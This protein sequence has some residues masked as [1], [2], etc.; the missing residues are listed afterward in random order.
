MDTHP[1]D[2]SAHVAALDGGSASDAAHDEHAA[3]NLAS[4]DERAPA[5]AASPDYHV[6]D[7]VADPG[8]ISDVVRFDLPRLGDVG[9]LCG[10]HLQCHVGTDT[11]SLA[12]LGA[13]MTGLDFSPVAIDQARALAER[14]GTPA[15]FVVSDVYAAV[16]VLEPGA[17]DLVFTGIGA[18]CWI[19]DIRRW[20]GVVSDLLAP[21]GRLFLREGHP[22]LW[23]LA[24]PDDSGTLRVEHPYFERPEPTRW[25]EG[26]T[27]VQTDV[28]FQ[29]NVSYE[30]NHGLGE[31]VTALLDQ[32][33]QITGLVEHDSIP[34][35]GL[36]G[37]MEP[38][39]GGELRLI[40]RP[41]RLAASYT[42]QATKPG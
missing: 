19:P 38:I 11:I 25:D 39:G 13:R 7:F 3:V 23:A 24:D 6:D 32:G 10:V 5:H 18:L 41:E 33:L 16:D 22:M 34:W 40:E 27:Y 21:G 29:H 30:W 28:E 12:R 31:I 20:A 37:L 17:F 14:C 4:W 15:R 26:G 36:P 8:Y 42:L 2:S 35:D 1:M 9:G